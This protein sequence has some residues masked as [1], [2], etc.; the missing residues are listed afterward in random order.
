[1]NYIHKDLCR[2]LQFDKSKFKLV[3]MPRYSFKSCIIT[4]GF[5]LWNIVLN[6]NDRQLIYSDSATKA[7]GFLQGVKNFI[8]GKSGRFREYFGKWETDPHN[9]K[10]NESQIVVSKRTS[11]SVESNID[12]GGIESSKVGLHFDRIFFDDIVSDLNVTTKAQMDKVYDCYKKSLS[13]LKPGGDII[14]CGTRWAHGDAYGRIINENKGNFSI[15]IKNALEDNGKE[16]PFSDAGLTREFL[17]NQKREQGSYIFSSLYMNNP[18]PDEESLFKHDL[19][20]FYGERIDTGMFYKICTL[21][22]AGEGDDCTAIVVCGVD[23][24]LNIYILD[25]VN[26]HLK[27]NQIVNEVIRLNYKWH[28]TK[29]GV[30]SNF[31]RGMLEK[32]IELA[33]QENGGNKDFTPFSKEIFIASAKRGEGKFARIQALQPYHERG[34]LLFPGDKVEHLKGAFAEL[35]SQMILFT[36][37]HRPLHDDLIDALA[38]QVKLIRPGGTVSHNRIVPYSYDWIEKK[39]QEKSAKIERMLPLKYRKRFSYV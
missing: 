9:G 38:Y 29:L 1:M 17:E 21:D 23:K 39:E 15:F 3:L 28:Y 10:W 18:V 26:G 2:F 33:Q 36:P 34:Q 35:A 14:L 13:L 12:T 8:E 5:G 32:E 6:P 31:F 20:S 4:Q 11:A 27:P 24:D 19:F 22:P 37:N 30:E 25:C 7:Q 16:Y